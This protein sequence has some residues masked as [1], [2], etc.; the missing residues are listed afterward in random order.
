LLDVLTHGVTLFQHAPHTHIGSSVIHTVRAE[1][2][3]GFRPASHTLMIAPTPEVAGPD[4]RTLA[5]EHALDELPS[6]HSRRLPSKSSAETDRLLLEIAASLV[7][8]GAVTPALPL[9]ATAASAGPDECERSPSPW[10]DPETDFGEEFPWAGEGLGLVISLAQSGKIAAEDRAER[11]Q[12]IKIR[13][14]TSVSFPS[15]KPWRGSRKKG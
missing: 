6:I 9:Q 12:R 15:R 2:V 5:W 10:D 11:Q 3:A 1:P 8:T 4:P 7:P 14:G 13:G